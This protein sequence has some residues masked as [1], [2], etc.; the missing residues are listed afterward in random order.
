MD[1]DNFDFEVPSFE[2]SVM[3][4]EESYMRVTKPNDFWWAFHGYSLKDHVRTMTDFNDFAKIVTTFEEARP[5]VTSVYDVLRN[6]Y[7]NTEDYEACQKC[8]TIEQDLRFQFLK[9]QMHYEKVEQNTKER[10]ELRRKLH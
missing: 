4:E 10:N 2:E 1:F 6:Y 5:L 9:L 8:V 7:E 3:L